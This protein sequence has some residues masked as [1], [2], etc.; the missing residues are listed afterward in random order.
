MTMKK[1]L[2]LSLALS[3]TL[4]G[5]KSEPDFGD[6][7]FMT[8]TLT[9]SNVRFLVDGTSS[10]GLTVSSS[11]KAEENV[12]VEVAVAPDLLEGYNASTGR[13][14][15]LPPEG[16]YSLVGQQVTIET[17][18]S[19]STPVE[20]TAEAGKLQDGVSYCLPVTI[21]KV[22]GGSLGILQSSR[23]AYVTFNKVIT[24]KVA[25]LGGGSYFDIPTFKGEES[26]VWALGKM[27]LEI[28]VRPSALT[29]AISESYINPI[30]GS[31]ESLLLRFGDGSNIP[32]N[33][34]NFAKVSIG[35]DYHPDNK[36]HYE[37][38]LET[39]FEN[40]KWYHI[41]VVYDG[42]KVKFYL[43]G[44]LSVEKSTE[45]GQIN[46]AMSYGG[47]GWDDTFAIGRSYGTRWTYKGCL[48]ECRVWNVDRSQS[49]L[50]D[51][52][53]YVNP[54]SEGLIASWRFNGELQEDGTVLDETG[55]GHNAHPNGTVNW[56][57]NQK[58]PF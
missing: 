56:P 49:Q 29:S 18:K 25:Q 8:G 2:F 38:T 26:P 21:S 20:I 40:D 58:C 28:K 52:M 43:N 19:V 53:C 7:I 34:L 32:S 5:C 50:Q 47:H 39:V 57:D 3:L 55:H 45:G 15:Q 30:L 16:S 12:N 37:T 14:Y 6:A 11:A 33:K 17:G 9:T 36:P 48:S 27:T 4:A 46:L 41:A 31:H 44:E 51:G 13:S 42:S 24:S 22:D 1:Y 54:T 23:T 10:I 35:S